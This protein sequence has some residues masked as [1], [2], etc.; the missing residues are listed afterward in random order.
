[1][2]TRT[3]R[4]GVLDSTGTLERA[5]GAAAVPGTGGVVALPS[6]VAGTVLLSGVGSGGRAATGVLRAYGADGAI[7]D[8]RRVRVA[9]GRTVAIPVAS[10]GTAVAGLDLVP[11]AKGAALAWSVLASVVEP[12]GELVSLLTPV[13]DAIAQPSVDVRRATTLGLP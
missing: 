3:G 10:L 11:D 5:W 8:E 7:L 1:M 9:A 6:G 12:D 13:P 4:P 2:I